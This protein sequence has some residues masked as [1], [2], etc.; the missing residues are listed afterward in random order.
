M[1]KWPHHNITRTT[2]Y[3]L[4]SELPQSKQQVTPMVEREVKT[5]RFSSLQNRM[6]IP[7]SA[8]QNLAFCLQSYEMKRNTVQHVV[9]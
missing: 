1:Y 7:V 4:T 8:P 9:V 3:I 2:H 6:N 5:N